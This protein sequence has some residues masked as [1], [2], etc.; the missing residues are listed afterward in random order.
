MVLLFFTTSMLKSPGLDYGGSDRGAH[1]NSAA[2]HLG[3]TPVFQRGQRQIQKGSL[4]VKTGPVPTWWTRTDREARDYSTVESNAAMTPF[5]PKLEYPY[6]KAGYTAAD[7]AKAEDQ[8]LA[9]MQERA[10]AKGF[11]YYGELAPLS[12]H[13]PFD[14]HDRDFW[15]LLG[16]ISERE[17]AAGRGMLSAIVVHKGA[18]GENIGPGDGFY[19]VAAQLGRNVS[20]RLR[21]WT[22]EF[23]RVHNCWQGHRPTKG[24]H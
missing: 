7:Y 17:D 14:A 20:D 5:I 9:L 6:L 15:A 4:G 10:E 24:K 8:I 1:L 11:Y 18:N 16:R 2:R 13:V 12:K 19:T 21:C 3:H 23:N 22:D